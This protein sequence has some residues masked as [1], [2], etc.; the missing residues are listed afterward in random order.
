[1]VR[2]FTGPYIQGLVQT[3]KWGTGDPDTVTSTNLKYYLHDNESL[4]WNYA[5]DRLTNP[6][7]GQAINATE[8]GAIASTKSEAHIAWSVLN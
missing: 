2:Y 7:D 8:E 5:T 4:N 6:F 3:R 1:M